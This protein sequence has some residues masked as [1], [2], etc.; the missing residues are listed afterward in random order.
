MFL[1]G[2]CTTTSRL[3]DAIDNVPLHSHPVLELKL[4]VGSDKFVGPLDTKYKVYHS[5]KWPDHIA[6]ITGGYRKEAWDCDDKA[7]E[8]MLQTRRAFYLF[9]KEK[10]TPAI[11]LAI[12]KLKK[13]FLGIPSN[14][15]S[16][17]ALCV[18]YT[19]DQGWMFYEEQTGLKIGMFEGIT[20]GYVSVLWVMF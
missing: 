9:N 5:E 20:K 14:G 15:G 2:G 12:V 7:L 16:K 11:G 17:H 13:R 6:G 3:A 18:I 10:R 19:S 1:M 8:A 4:L